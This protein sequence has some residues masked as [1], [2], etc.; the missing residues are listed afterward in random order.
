MRLYAREWLAGALFALSFIL[1]RI[2]ATSA[3][4]SLGRWA[5]T[6]PLVIGVCLFAPTLLDPNDRP[7][8]GP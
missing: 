7:R 8:R 4:G 6:I 5:M 1:S 3:P 2:F